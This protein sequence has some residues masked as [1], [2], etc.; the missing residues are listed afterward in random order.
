[1]TTTEK[2]TNGNHNGSAPKERSEAPN[3]KRLLRLPPAKNRAA[4]TIFY[5]GDRLQQFE[6][7]IPKERVDDWQSLLAT[8]VIAVNEM[9]PE[10]PCTTLS[11][12]KSVY[13]GV[14]LGLPCGAPLNHAY[15][16]PYK[17]TRASE[18]SNK[19]GGPDVYD[20]QLVIGYP[21]YIDLALGSGF[22]SDI[23]AELVIGA[24]V[25]TFEHFIDRSGRQVHHRIPVSRERPTKDN[26]H[27]AYCCWTTASGKSYVHVTT[28]DVLRELSAKWLRSP[29][30]YHAMALKTPIRHAAKFWKKTKYL[31]AAVQLDEQLED[32]E[33]GQ[34][35][36]GFDSPQGP[37]DFSL[38]DLEEAN[39]EVG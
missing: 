19:N 33:G 30:P 4:T 39:W 29:A 28:R 12:A 11:I 38:D 6:L 2:I 37:E 13:N 7:A 3:G 35:A 22:Y 23:T 10:K 21:G 32:G 14:R 18:L 36:P 15:L 9:D 34:D 26:V 16:V 27:A 17:N 1:M 8:Y 31:A 25:D 5:E 20:M 24:E